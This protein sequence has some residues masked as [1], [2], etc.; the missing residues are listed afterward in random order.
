MLAWCTF[1]DVQCREQYAGAVRCAVLE[2]AS[3]YCVN[4]YSRVFMEMGDS[5]LEKD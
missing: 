2:T 1:K 4:I 3:G 5:G